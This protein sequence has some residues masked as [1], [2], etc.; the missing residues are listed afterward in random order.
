MRTW[1]A[2]QC[3]C[4]CQ[5]RQVCQSPHGG[6]AAA[7][8]FLK[9]LNCCFSET[10]VQSIRSSYTKGVWKQRANDEG[11]I[12]GNEATALSKS[13]YHKKFPWVVPTTKYLYT[14]IKNTNSLTWNFQIHEPATGTKKAYN[15]ERLVQKTKTAQVDHAP[16]SGPPSRRPHPQLDHALN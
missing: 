4:L 3:Q 7:R 14:K 5:D 13:T 8:Y 11:D 2:I 15:S 6:T 1:H 12:V 9:K 10:T 16:S